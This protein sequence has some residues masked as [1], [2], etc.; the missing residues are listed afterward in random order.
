MRKGKRA[1]SRVEVSWPVTMLTGKKVITGEIKDI[2]LG[3]ALIRCQEVLSQ[4]RSLKLRIEITDLFSVSAT[5]ENVRCH[6]DESHRGP[7]TCYLAVRFTDM[8]KDQNRILYNAIARET[9]GQ[10]R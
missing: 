9:S 4:E 7:T 5:V 1:Y 2:S 3:G 8:T 10:G 6:S